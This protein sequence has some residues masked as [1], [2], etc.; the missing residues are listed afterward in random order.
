M[1]LFYS[2][3]KVKHRGTAYDELK[4]AIGEQMWKQVCS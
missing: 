2:Y 1:N 4:D 3:V